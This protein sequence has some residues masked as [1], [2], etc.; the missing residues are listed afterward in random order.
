V[1][2][3]WL[4][5]DVCAPPGQDYEEL[6]ANLLSKF[7][8]RA[9]ATF[10]MSNPD[11]CRTIA[12]FC[13]VYDLLQ[14]GPVNRLWNETV[15]SQFHEIR[16]Q[17]D[18]KYVIFKSHPLYDT[19]RKMVSRLVNNRDHN[20]AQVY[21]LGGA[22]HANNKA[23]YMLKDTLYVISYSEGFVTPQE[24]IVCSAAAADLAGNYC[25]FGGWKDTEQR[26]VDTAWKMDF[27]EPDLNETEIPPLP[28][29]CCFGGVDCT[30]Q[31]DFIHTGGGDTPFNGAE[32]YADVFLLKNGAKRWEYNTIPNMHTVRCG[33]RA[34]TLFNDSL[35]VA[36]G[37]AGNNVFLSSAEVLDS[38]L[39]RWISLPDMN[40]AR[41]GAASVLGP[42]GVMYMCGGTPNSA[43]S[44][45]SVERYDPR[46]GKWT[47][48]APML[49]ERSF[50]AACQSVHHG[51]YV[52]GGMVGGA[53]CDSIEFYDY[54]MDMWAYHVG[55]TSESPEL[56]KISAYMT[57][58][59]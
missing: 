5:A 36:G 25:L 57:L 46:E 27:D 51:F 31:G 11:L 19:D 48:M 56:N 50:A 55:G 38:R 41:S 43:D 54:R 39:D 53:V 17:R 35:L 21:I 7:D 33:H 59:L 16:H 18:L 47:L 14:L 2:D 3:D 45:S 24:G 26:C 6:Y 22:M 40:A 20:S 49:N 9:T 23:T 34:V 58:K 28:T 12:S 44:L 4:D 15:Q 42:G 52:M 8:D 1:G 32:C 29:A 10:C 30:I 13:S 37:Y